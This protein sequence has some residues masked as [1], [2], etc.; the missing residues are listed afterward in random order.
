M[1]LWEDVWKHGTGTA[2]YS[3]FIH[4]HHSESVVIEN[5]FV[6]GI[7]ALQTRDESMLIRN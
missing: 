2:S 3:L 5:I 4:H 7:T 6:E 1:K